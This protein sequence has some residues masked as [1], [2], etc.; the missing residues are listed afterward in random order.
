MYLY[1]YSCSPTLEEFLLKRVLVLF[2][3]T[4]SYL[5]SNI[6]IFKILRYEENIVPK[7]KFKG[8]NRRILIKKRH[9]VASLTYRQISNK[10]N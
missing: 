8:P 6:S 10:I 3:Y 9:E 4:T 7:K 1:Y 5:A 2:R